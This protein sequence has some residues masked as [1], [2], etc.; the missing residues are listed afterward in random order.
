MEREEEMDSKAEKKLSGN[1][2]REEDRIQ[3]VQ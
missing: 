3:K 1:E 2:V